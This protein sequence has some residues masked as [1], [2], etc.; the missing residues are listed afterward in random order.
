MRVYPFIALVLSVSNVHLALGALEDDQHGGAERRGRVTFY[1]HAGFRGG[2]ITL[3]AGQ[4][5]EN[6]T[7][8]RF[9][10]G[11]G[12]NDRISSIRIE[13]DVEVTVFQ[14]ADFRG[15]MRKFENS[16][17]DLNAS[18]PGWNDAI[19]SLRVETDR[20]R[21]RD[22]REV[23]RADERIQRAYRDVLGREPDEQSLNSYRKHLLDDRWS[24]E[25]LRHSIGESAEFREGVDRIVTSAFGD[26]L[27]RIPT[28]RERSKFSGHIIK[29][30]WSEEDVRNVLRGS[31]EYRR[32][33]RAP[34][35]Q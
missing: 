33:Q 22:N 9:T 32:L 16:V 30:K 1:E 8:A 25:Q 35:S 6:L 14:D 18:A 34:G 23:R 21:G 24:D 4:A 19:S 12:M 20:E 29:D 13:G 2:S 10:N 3:E 27:G 7:R 31:D 26:L 17:S 28:R 15:G 5:L 11:E